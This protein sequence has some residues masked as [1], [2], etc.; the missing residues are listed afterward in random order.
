VEK[1]EKRI[2]QVEKRIKRE[3]EKEHIKKMKEEKSTRVP[4]R[5]H[6]LSPRVLAVVSVTFT[7]EKISRRV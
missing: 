2:N 3:E 4:S 5:G 6:A 1:E 7:D